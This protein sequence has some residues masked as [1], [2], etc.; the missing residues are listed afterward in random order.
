MSNQEFENYLRLI[1]K[2]LQL[3]RSQQKQ[4]SGELRDHLQSRVADLVAEGVAQEDAVGAGAG[5]IRRCCGDG[6]EFSDSY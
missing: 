3:S 2:L 6:E 5:G 1:G 4:I